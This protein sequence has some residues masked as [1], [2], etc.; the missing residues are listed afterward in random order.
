MKEIIGLPGME[1]ANTE[2]VLSEMDEMW[3]GRKS[4]RW[5]DTDL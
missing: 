2:K 5:Y 3:G 1:M 4:W